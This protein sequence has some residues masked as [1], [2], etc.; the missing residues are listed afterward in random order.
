MQSNATLATPSP[1]RV[2]G[3]QISQAH[4]LL[5]L[6]AGVIAAAMLLPLAYLIFRCPRRGRAC[7]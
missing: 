7:V 1:R 4:A 2:R 3:T 6:L 5:N